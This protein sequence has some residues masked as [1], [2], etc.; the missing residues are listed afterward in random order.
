MKTVAALA[1]VAG[2]AGAALPTTVAAETL[3]IFGDETTG[4]TTTTDR[5]GTVTSVATAGFD[6]LLVDV[7]DGERVLARAQF[8]MTIATNGDELRGATIVYTQSGRR[9]ASVTVTITID[10]CWFELANERDFT[11]ADF[12]VDVGEKI[13]GALAPG[14]FEPCVKEWLEQRLSLLAARIAEP[15]LKAGVTLVPP[16]S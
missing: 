3:R 15:N 6:G 14:T 16:R 8:T 12:G 2:L 13:E 10:P 5:D 11:S 1:F 9:A 4:L 7:E